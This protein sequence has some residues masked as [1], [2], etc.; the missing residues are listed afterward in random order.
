[1]ATRS[2]TNNVL[3]GMLVTAAIV[4]SVAIVIV[5]SGAF[6]GLGKVGYTVR[7]DLGTGVSGLQPGAEV[8]LGGRKIGSVGSVEFAR[9]GENDAPSG[10]DVGIDVYS[11]LVFREN[12]RAY[13]EVPLLGGG[14]VINFPSLGAT[15]AEIEPGATIEGA[16]APPAFLAQA[17]FGEDQ[18]AAVQR[19][20]ADVESFASG[21]RAIPDQ[22]TEFIDGAQPTI[23]NVNEL[24]A[25]IL[26]Q[27]NEKWLGRVD[28]ITANVKTASEDI[29][30]FVDNLSTRVDE[31][32]ELLATGQAYLDDNRPQIDA[33]IDNFERL[34]GQG[35]DFAE[36]LN[37]ELSERTLDL[38]DTGKAELERAGGAV[39]RIGQNLENVLEE[40]KPTIRKA[41]ANLRLASDQLRTT[42]IEVR[43]TP[44]RLIYRPDTS[45]LEYELLYDAAR[46]YA[47]AV[48]DLRAATESLES[49]RRAAA[50]GNDVSSAQLGDL[51]EQ[52]DAAFA[53]YKS[54]EERF[55]QELSREA[56]ER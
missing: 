8:R 19:I 53:D 41:M 51:V 26:E 20:I 30:P 9:A 38:L 43:R 14:G 11:D 31:L 15:G 13:L 17:G 10:I 46:S 48:S 6:D 12:A 39:E 45:E 34:T 36:R 21:A 23:D 54:A 4:A 2:Q 18:A 24:T 37:T 22:L 29:E 55:L 33:S 16:I 47:L 25:S 50:T 35:A 1:M 40:H 56:G 44:W 7:F 32:G 28:T 5:L 3:A 27:W 52:I 42:L 49:V